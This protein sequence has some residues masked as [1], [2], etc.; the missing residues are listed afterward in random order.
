MTAVLELRDI[1]VW[2]GGVKAVDGV[3]LALE[4]GHLHALVGPNG[5]GKTTV[6]NT[7]SRLV[8]PTAGQVF[9]DGQDVTAAGPHEVYRRGLART[10]QGIRLV[11]GLTVRENVLLGVQ[12]LPA[13]R[14]RAGRRRAA[15]A[16][17]EA[18]ERMDVHHLAQVAPAA[19]PYGVQRR[20]EIARAVAGAPKILLLDEPVAGMSAGERQEISAVLGR[21]RDDGMTML[22]IEHDLRFVLGL[23]D[24][25][26]VLNFGQLLAAGDPA[27]TAALPAVQEAFLGRK[28]VP[29]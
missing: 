10:F 17:D 14:S 24:H 23:S 27:A 19:L 2:F 15:E 13:A 22:L 6:V 1:K 26:F 3:S 12:E 21:L 18:L 11:E 4:P 7:M 25:L 9:L 29:A 16:A 8:T 20:V 28:H 5:S